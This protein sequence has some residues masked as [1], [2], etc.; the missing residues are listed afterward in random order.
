M[1]IVN[2][3][4]GKFKGYRLFSQKFTFLYWFY[5]LVV[6]YYIYYLDK[7]FSQWYC[8]A[9]VITKTMTSHVAIIS[10]VMTWDA[11]SNTV[12]ITSFILPCR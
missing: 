7:P 8:F 6:S 5:S 3:R 4:R 9:L 12:Q 2:F 1:D 10:N 11:K